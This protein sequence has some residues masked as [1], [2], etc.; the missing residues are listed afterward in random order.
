VG[1]AAIALATERIRIGT[2]V[3]PL[4]RRRPWKLAREAIT[5]DHLSERRLT[6]GVGLGGPDDVENFDR[7]GE[8]TGAKRRA[9]MLDE[10]LEI[11]AGLWSGELFS[12]QGTHY[13]VEETTF[14]PKPVQRPRIPIW[15]GGSA[16]NKGVVRRAARWDGIV[17]VPVP[18]G[19]GARYLTPDEVKALRATVERERGKVKRTGP[20][21]SPLADYR[22]AMIGRRSEIELHP[23]PR[24]VSPGGWSGFPRRTRPLC[25]LP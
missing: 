7:L 16:H 9:E 25:T 15:V 2:T 3:T 21:I 8:A 10:G 11:L 6:L 1:L 13:R 20:S 19:G 22:E 23:S 5:I 4:P 12:Y 18:L 24:Q 14:L 17:P